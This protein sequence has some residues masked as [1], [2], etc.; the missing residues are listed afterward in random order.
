MTKILNFL[1]R[2][3]YLMYFG[4]FVCFILMLGF[5][6]DIEYIFVFNYQCDGS[7]TSI[8]NVI[9]YNEKYKTFNY[10]IKH[11]YDIKIKLYWAAALYNINIEDLPLILKIFDKYNYLSYKELIKLCQLKDFFF[12]WKS[13]MII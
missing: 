2:K 7:I 11:F 4:Y 12:L 1:K 9:N 3:V 13:C 10:S 6:L 5:V 8:Y